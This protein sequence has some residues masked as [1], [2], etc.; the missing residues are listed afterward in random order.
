[1]TRV[2]TAEAVPANRD[3]AA[4]ARD[5]TSD[6]DRSHPADSGRRG[7]DRRLARVTPKP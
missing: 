3:N 7:E 6:L 1:M 5:Q 2:D 4:T